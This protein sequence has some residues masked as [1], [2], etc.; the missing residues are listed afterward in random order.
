MTTRRITV[1]HF[2]TEPTRGGVEEHM[3]LL[4][5]Q[6][7]RQR[8]RLHLVCRPELAKKLEPDLPGDVEVTPMHLEHPRHVAAGLRFARILRNRHVDILHSHLSRASVVASPIAWFCRV[9]VIVETPHV[10]ELWRRGWLKGHFLADRLV[11]HCVDRYIAVSDSNAQ[12]L[13]ETKG[14]PARK[15]MV[16]QNGCDLNRFR[17]D[18]R[19]SSD[20]KKLFG[21]AES[22]LVLVVVARLEPQKGHRALIEAMKLVCARFPTAR[23]VCVGEGSQ[24][25]D[26]E[27]Q[28]RQMGLEASLRFVGYQSNTPEWLALADVVVLPS[29]YEGLP[30]VAI[31]TLAAGRPMVATA[32]D[33][34][35]EVIVN[36]KTGL[37]VPPGNPKLLA[38]A[39]CRLLREPELRAAFG[40]AGRS[41]VLARFS[42]ERQIQQTEDLYLRAWDEY[43]RRTHA[44]TASCAGDGLVIERGQK[45]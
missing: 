42:Q 34:T 9:P 4:L 11:G 24:R 15:I 45:P 29:F 14:L 2:S 39:I 13:V 7:D 25:G 19:P 6:L 17:P 38:A 41:W 33:G 32:V 43:L 35:V 23:L 44:A 20:L 12:Y 10:R 22:D 37:T 36:E 1:L 30:L 5:R 16:I 18:P 8:F 3:L 21:F 31:E 28:T 40:R 27:D 26:L